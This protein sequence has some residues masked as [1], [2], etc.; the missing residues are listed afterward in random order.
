MRKSRV[1]RKKYLLPL[2][3]IIPFLV[4]FSYLWVFGIN[5]VKASMLLTNT[6]KPKVEYKTFEINIDEN[7][8]ESLKTHIISSLE[9]IKFN[10]KPRFEFTNGKIADY[11]ISD[12]TDSI[13]IFSQTYI[14]V[15]HIYWIKGDI[16]TKDICNSS[17]YV[18]DDISDFSLDLLSD[19]LGSSC[20]FEKKS[21]LVEALKSSENHIGLVTLTKL[22]KE[23]KV[24]KMNKEGYFDNPESSFSFSYSIESG[25]DDLDFVSSIIK[26]NLDLQTEDGFN[27]ENI[28][29]INMTGV[30]AITRGLAMKIEASKDYGYPARSIGKFLADAD[31][32]HVSNETSFIDGCTSFSGMRFCSKPEYLKT[33]IDSGVDIVELTGNHNNDYGS[34]ANTNT[35]NI[36]KENG[37]EYFGG[38]LDD[39]DASKI[40]YK[41]VKGSTI[42]FI[43]YNYYDTMQRTGAIAAANHAGSNS[44]S[45]EKLEEDIKEARSNADVVIVDIQFQEC[46]SYPDGDVIFPIC[47]KPISAPDQKGV[48]RNAVDLGADIVIGTQAHQPQT[49]EVYNGG[50]IFYGLGNLYFD[51]VRWIGTRQGLVISIYIVDGK[52]IQTELTP[53]IYDRDIIT[54]VAKDDEA[55]LLLELLKSARTF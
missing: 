53:T 29:K 43:G 14:P 19:S 41:E 6:A 1:V 24:L 52:V 48:F 26:N 13:P 15:G 33:L 23:M 40:L 20:I 9:A 18:N 50:T 39:T 37:L 42:A 44:Y 34:T 12:S 21:N 32:T 4:F 35:I 2:C 46:Y 3:A 27:P 7:L 16:L 38:G 28:V 17:V 25:E 54:R 5:P 51:Q 47:Y 22:T 45:V 36:Y 55:K 30:T 8:P 31:I 11:F 10:D 49:Y